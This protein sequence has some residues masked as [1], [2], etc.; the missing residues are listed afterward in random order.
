MSGENSRNIA[1]SESNKQIV[2]IAV[3]LLSTGVAVKID[4]SGGQSMI[5]KLQFI[6]HR[7]GVR[8]DQK[9]G[10]ISSYS[11]ALA[12]FLTSAAWMQT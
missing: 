7:P 9:A 1:E 12:E 6:I 11:L 3:K 4:D 2:D 10:C 8:S 5:G